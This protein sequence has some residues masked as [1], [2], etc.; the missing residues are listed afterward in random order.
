MDTAG[1]G[2]DWTVS[3]GASLRAV[4]VGGR[5]GFTVRFASVHA[6]STLGGPQ[7]APREALSRCR[8]A[9]PG[10][11]V[12]IVRHAGPQLRPSHDEAGE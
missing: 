2:S 5:A 9:W 7:K 3:G 4:S 6:G 10:R 12:Q 8:H 1:S 11:S